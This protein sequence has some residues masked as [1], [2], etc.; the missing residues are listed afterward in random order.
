VRSDVFRGDACVVSTKQNGAISQMTPEQINY[1]F[2]CDFN[3]KRS[4]KIYEVFQSVVCHRVWHRALVTC[5][6][7]SEDRLTLKIDSA[8]ASKRRII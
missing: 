6:D 7:I 2:N 1:T 3:P 4:I 5:S 8:L